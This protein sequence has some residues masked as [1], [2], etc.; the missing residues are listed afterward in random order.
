MLE[1]GLVEVDAT[2]VL[3]PVGGAEDREARLGLLEHADV[4]RAAAEV[5]DRDPVARRQPRAGGVLGG[6]GLGLGAG[7][8]GAGTSASVTIWWRSSRL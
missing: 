7:D 8:R 2:E 6:G 1:H 3:D 5:V 4:E